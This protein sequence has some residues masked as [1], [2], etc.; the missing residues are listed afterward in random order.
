MDLAVGYTDAHYTADALDPNS[1]VLLAA[2]GDVLD[3]APWTVSLGAQYDFTLMDHDGFIRADYEFQSRRTHAIP[4]E[5]PLVVNFYDPGLVP[6]PATNLVSLR[7]GMTFTKFNVALYVD[8]LFDAHP[9]LDLQHQDGGT[10][11]FEANTFRPRT[12][13]VALD[14]RY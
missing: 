13:G 14:Y 1:G 12:I 8:N 3:V 11:L 7:T 2:K 4:A 6:N 10:A 5:D 9:Q